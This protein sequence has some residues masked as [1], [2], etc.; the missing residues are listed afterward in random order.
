VS[1]LLELIICWKKTQ[2]EHKYNCYKLKTLESVKNKNLVLGLTQENSIEF[3][4]QTCL[5]YIY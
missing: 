1:R 3:L 4:I 2:S 5:P